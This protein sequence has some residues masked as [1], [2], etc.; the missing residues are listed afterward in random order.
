[1]ET[2]KINTQNVKQTFLLVYI[3]E[4]K[5]VFSTWLCNCFQKGTSSPIYPNMSFRDLVQDG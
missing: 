1:M 4:N 5:G 2:W 3:E